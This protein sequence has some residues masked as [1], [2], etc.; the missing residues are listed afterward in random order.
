MTNDLIFTFFSSTFISQ[1]IEYTEITFC[2]I[3]YYFP[4]E[5]FQ[6]TEIDQRKLFLNM[7]HI[8]PI[9]TNL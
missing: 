4:L 1:V 9:F 3:L 5:T 2:I 6:I 7:L 8:S